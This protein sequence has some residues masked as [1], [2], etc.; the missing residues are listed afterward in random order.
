MTRKRLRWPILAT[1]ILIAVI[2]LVVTI[3]GLYQSYKSNKETKAL[4]QAEG[5][6]L[7]AEGKAWEASEAFRRNELAESRQKWAEASAEYMKAFSYYHNLGALVPG[8]FY[9]GMAENYMQLGDLGRSKDAFDK[10]KDAFFK[11][12]HAQFYL[13]KPQTLDELALDHV[14]LGRRLFRSGKTQDAIVQYRYGLSRF[15]AETDNKHLPEIESL[16]GVGQR[17]EAR[18]VSVGGESGV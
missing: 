7:Q 4:L 15:G 9:K 2:A 3:P 16:L 5:A 18:A 8:E 17:E 12:E 10:A 13:S 6:L 11:A 14:Q 1:A